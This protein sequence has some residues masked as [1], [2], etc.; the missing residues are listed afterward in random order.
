MGFI[1]MGSSLIIGGGLIAIAILAITN[2]I[3]KYLTLS[4][5]ILALLGGLILLSFPIKFMIS[6]I[7]QLL[8]TDFNYKNRAAKSCSILFPNIYFNPYQQLP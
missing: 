3:L 7:L 4:I 6:Y 1:L 5:G 8:S 2:H